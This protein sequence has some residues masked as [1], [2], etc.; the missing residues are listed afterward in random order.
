M[1]QN[2]T[3]TEGSVVK[4]RY[5]FYLFLHPV[6]ILSCPYRNN[7]C[8][9]RSVYVYMYTCESVYVH[10]YTYIVL[11]YFLTLN[12]NVLPLLF[13]LKNVISEIMVYLNLTPFKGSYYSIVFVC[14]TLN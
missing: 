4:R 6:K 1:T 13:K 5:A 9:Y 7:L 10:M 11:S 2:S 8:N 14:L 3:G 12:Y